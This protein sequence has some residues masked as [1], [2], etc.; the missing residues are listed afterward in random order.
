MNNIHRL[1]LNLLLLLDAMFERRSVTGVAL[2]LGVSQPTVSVGL[3][4][5]RDF[6]QDDLFRRTREGMVPTAFAATLRAPVS[7]A[8]GLLDRQVFH[9]ARFDPLTSTRTLTLCM[10]E[11]GE[12][13]Y[14]PRLAQAL[15]E[16]A[17][18]LTLRTLNLEPAQI[19]DAMNS[20]MVDLAL[21]HFPE[22]DPAVIASEQLTSHRLACL[23]RKGH[24]TMSDPATLEAFV[25]GEHVVVMPVNRPYSLYIEEIARLNIALR[26]RLRPANFSSLPQLIRT[27]DLIA[28]APR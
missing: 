6:F 13:I 22:L 10:S 21:G 11:A 17:P 20:G 7:E 4:K 16:Q 9:A 15:A 23:V 27:S 24:P 12:L 3:G 28:V 1:D 2:H 26:I 18:H 25:R 8:L 14:L 5:L 19:R